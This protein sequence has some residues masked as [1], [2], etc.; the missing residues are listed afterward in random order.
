MGDAG[1]GSPYQRLKVLG[2]DAADLIELAAIKLIKL[3]MDKAAWAK[4]MVADVGERIKPHLN[5]L[6]I[7]AIDR[8]KQTRRQALMDSRPMEIPEDRKIYVPTN[9]KR[10]DMIH[11]VTQWAQDKGIYGEYEN[12]YQPYDKP[13]IVSK[14][15]IETALWHGTGPQKIRLI[16]VLPEMLREAVPVVS[17]PSSKNPQ[18]MDHVYAT[19]V[20]VDGRDYMVGLVVHQDHMGRRFYDHELTQVDQLVGNEKVELSTSDSH[21]ENKTRRRPESADR[22]HILSIIHDFVKSKS[23]VSSADVSPLVDTVNRAGNIN[24]RRINTIDAIKDVIRETVV[25]RAE[26]TDQARRDIWGRE[27]KKSGNGLNCFASPAA[28]SESTVDRVYQKKLR[29]GLDIGMPSSKIRGWS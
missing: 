26:D 2:E 15:G 8:D 4:D 12:R 14:K 9:Y 17:H 20:R 29:L 25:R 13:I 16:G 21:A 27:I 19:K 18:I 5:D 1:G 11:R 6:W 7:A 28:I 23:D 3:G 10:D 24:L 22:P